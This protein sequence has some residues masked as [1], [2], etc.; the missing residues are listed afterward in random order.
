MML[1][2]SKIFTPISIIIGTENASI[3]TANSL[4]IIQKTGELACT[5]KRGKTGIVVFNIYQTS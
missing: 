3:P 5:D 4:I 1:K 2:I